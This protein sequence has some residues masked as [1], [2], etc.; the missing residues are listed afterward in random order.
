[1][2]RTALVLSS[3][4]CLL[5]AL[6]VAAEPGF[7][8]LFNGRNLDGWQL[9]HGRGTGYVVENGMIVCP[10]DGGGN[11]FTAKEYGDFVLRFEFKLSEGGNNGIGIRAPLEGDAAYVGMEIQ[12]L[13]HDAPVYKGKLKPAQYHGSIYDVVPAKTGALKPTGEWNQEE[14]TAK[15]RHITVKLNGQTIVDAN[16]DDVTDP[17]VLKKHPGLAR[18]A[19]YIGLLGHGTRVEFRQFRIK[20][21]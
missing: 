18:K 7:K 5:P 19:G 3:L 20:E 4:A 1:M 21:M 10:A 15:G 16:L 9:V 8:D 11:L 14:I 17:A 6:A 13:D 12:V 2:K